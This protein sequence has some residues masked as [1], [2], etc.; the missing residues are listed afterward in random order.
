MDEYLKE[1][2]EDAIV[3]LQEG[4]ATN[5]EILEA[6]TAVAEDFEEAIQLKQ[7]YGIY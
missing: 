3:R 2:F 5:E 1:Q 6:M 7:P 4:G